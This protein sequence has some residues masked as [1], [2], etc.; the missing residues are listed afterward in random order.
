MAP[1]RSL[2]EMRTN[3]IQLIYDKGELSKELLPMNKDFEEEYRFVKKLENG[4]SR[5]LFYAINNLRFTNHFY[6]SFF[7][8]AFLIFPIDSTFRRI[9][10]PTKLPEIIR[11]TTLCKAIKV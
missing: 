2:K 1:K 10:T 5:D 3:L 7:Q 9:N 4:E 6:C 11:I 8:I